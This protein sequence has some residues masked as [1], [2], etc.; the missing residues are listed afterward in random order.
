MTQILVVHSESL[1]TAEPQAAFI[2]LV[3]RDMDC[4]VLFE[5]LLAAKGL[6]AI[7]ALVY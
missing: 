4:R 5:R 6:A 2:T 1:D 3:Q 7:I